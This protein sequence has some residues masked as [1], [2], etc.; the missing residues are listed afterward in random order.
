M[1]FRIGPRRG[2]SRGTGQPA[3]DP[4][5]P[6]TRRPHHRRHGLRK[7]SAIR[8][9]VLSFIAGWIHP[10]P[11]WGQPDDRAG[12]AEPPDNA[13]AGPVGWT[14]RVEPGVWY[15]SAGGRVILPG[16]VRGGQDIDMERINADSPRAGPHGA[17]SATRGRLRLGAR[18]FYFATDRDAIAD[19]NRQVGDVDIR[20][21]DPLQVDLAFGAYELEAGW[22]VLERPGSAEARAHTGARVFAFGG[23]RAYE[24]DMELVNRSDQ[25]TP[26]TADAASAHEL[27]AEPYVGLVLEAQVT[28]QLAL[29]LRGSIG[30]MY[31]DQDRHST[32][33][34]LTAGLT[35]QPHPNLGL[36]VGYRQL[37]FDL[38]SGGGAGRFEY[39][40]SLAGLMGSLVVRF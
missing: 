2:R 17:V 22:R 13:P 33:W 11:A 18:G 24:F 8:L 25:L 37:A 31:I 36:R 28:E 4:A 38:D 30:G 29:D 16:Q 12:P 15:A 21:G 10:P 6:A 27:F 35:W 3:H 14:V 39:R 23:A 32:S 19:I 26:G 7:G 1:T 5:A 20:V 34:D 40:G 9:A